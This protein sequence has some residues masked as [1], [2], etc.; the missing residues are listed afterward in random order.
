MKL[1][2]KVLDFIYPKGLTCNFC[3]K[4]L[5]E[6]DR[7]FSICPDCAMRFIP[8]DPTEIDGIKVYSC[9]EYDGAIRSIVLDYKD[10]D[11]PY[12][13]EYM[14]RYMYENFVQNGINAD[15]ICYVP[16]SPSALRRRGYDGMKIVAEHLNKLSAIP[17]SNAL[18]RREG[19]DQTKVA[20]ENRS[21]NVKDMFLSRE[22]FTGEVLLLDD[23]VT[24]GATVTE[25]AKTIIN[26][27]ADEV[28]V[29]TFAAAR[30]I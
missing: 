19:Q 23:V 15:M 14:A 4:E 29:L 30:R 22:G 25:C 9:F 20:H 26:H 11:K 7:Y 24:T 5:N 13:C 21:A 6:A 2:D 1:I 10:A 12:L 16:S 27:G 28:V 3:G 8:V 17:L 18:F